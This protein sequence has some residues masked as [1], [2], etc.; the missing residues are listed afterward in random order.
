MI[1]SVVLE[2]LSGQYRL[3]ADNKFYSKNSSGGKGYSVYSRSCWEYLKM[4]KKKGRYFPLIKL[5]QKTS[6]L[7]K[8]EESLEMQVSL[9]KRVHRTNLFEVDEGNIEEIH[10]LLLSDLKEVGVMT[11]I[12]KMRGA[13]VRRADFSKVI[14]LP[15]CLGRANQAIHT[16]SKFNYKPRSDF[17]LKEFYDGSEGVAMKFWNSTQGY[18]IYDKF[19][20]IISHGFTKIE[21]DT[22][23]AVKEKPSLRCA[24]KFE[25][26]LERK[27]SFEA[28]VRRRLKS[29]KKEN[30]TLA[31]ILNRDLAKAVLLDTFDKVFNNVSLGLITLSEM[32]ENE[33]LAY[34]D[35]QNISQQKRERLHHW[36]RMTAIF[37]IKG[38]WERLEA[39]YRGGSIQRTKKEVALARYELGE[40]QEKLPN[41]VAFLRQE[42]EKFEIIKPK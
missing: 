4:Q 23:E 3:T 22:A 20:E 5:P 21:K 36:V 12:E 41:L 42:H 28:V 7:G 19:G 1:D 9:P 34:L 37:G 24:I 25:L 10:S 29:D 26:S 16:L 14:K 6:G 31:E 33:L 13:F 30:F 2:L 15:P 11:D 8:T 38:A 39:V 32:G 17:D 18:A 40:I 35:G 27:K